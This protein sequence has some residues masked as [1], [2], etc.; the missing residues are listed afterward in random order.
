MSVI[1]IK[2]IKVSVIVPIYNVGKY[3]VKC[4]DSLLKQT[5]NNIEIILVDDGSPDNS[6]RICDKY[7][8]LDNRITVIHKDNHGVSAARNTG[9]DNA[10]GD[11]ICFVDGDD[12]VMEDYVEYLL[13]LC[14]DYNAEISLSERMFSNYRKAQITNDNIS[15]HSGEDAAVDI[16]CY[17]MAIGVYN[18]MFK[19]SLIGDRVRFIEKQFIGEGFNFNV[20]AFQLAKTVVIGYRRIYYYRQDNLDSATKKF[21]EKKWENGLQSIEDIKKNLIIR[22]NR[23]MR[24]WR[25]A[26]WR[27]NSDVFDLIVLSGSQKQCPDMFNKCLKVIKKWNYSAFKTETSR[28]ERLRALAFSIN[29]YIIPFVMKLRVKIYGIGKK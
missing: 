16:L 26:K 5:H 14:V 11:Y 18:K 4:I 1:H 7:S 22:S 8:N 21:S 17:K 2:D 15:V 23:M 6:G 25:Y 19:R 28:N 24:A 27:T 9:I 3:L 12:Y 29:P 10:S 20:T 13:K